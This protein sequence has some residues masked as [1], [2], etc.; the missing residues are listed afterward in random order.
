MSSRPTWATQADPVPK[1]YKN[2]TKKTMHKH[3]DTYKD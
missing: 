3:T 1:K 2:K